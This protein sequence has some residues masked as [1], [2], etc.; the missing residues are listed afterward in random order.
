MELAPRLAFWLITRH[1]RTAAAGV[2][3]MHIYVRDL[4]NVSRAPAVHAD[5]YS[6][7][8]RDHT[9]REILE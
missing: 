8:L 6:G 4:C 3:I 9:F 1:A 7:A 5:C 2:N